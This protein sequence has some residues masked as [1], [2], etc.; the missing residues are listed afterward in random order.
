MQLGAFSIKTS[1][2]VSRKFPLGSEGKTKLGAA[3][4]L[5]LTIQFVVG[6]LTGLTLIISGAERHLWDAWRARSEEVH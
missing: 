2:Q 4:H 5:L 3:M 1:R 6:L